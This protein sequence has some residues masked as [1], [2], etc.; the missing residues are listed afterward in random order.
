MN[1]DFVQACR[2]LI[3]FDTSPLQ[4]TVEMVNYLA[5]LA[6]EFG[7]DVQIQHEIQNG[8][9]Q[10]NI[11]I[12][13]QPFRPGDQEFLLQTHLDTVDPGSFSLWKKNSFNPFDAVIEDGKIFGLGA[14]EVKLD[15]LCKL[16][17]LIDLKDCHFKN[18]KPVLVGTFGEESGMQ[19][20]LKL[21][22]KNKINAKYALIGE[23]TNLNIVNS[24][25]G[26]ATVEIKIPISIE[27]QKHKSEKLISES[28]STQTK[29]F[30]GR[31]AHSSTPH[32]GESAAVKMF[33][34]LNQMPDQIVIVD[35]DSGTRVNTIPNQAMV[36]LDASAQI[37]QT[38]IR[39]IN[40]LFR[41]MSVVQEKM[42]IVTDADFEPMHSTLSVG[43]IRSHAEHI[44][45]GGSCRIL[46]S[47]SQDIYESWMNL[48]H[49]ACVEVGAEF[50]LLDYKR[51]FRTGENS[52][53]IK[54]AQ[55]ELQKLGIDSGCRSLASTN[56]ASLFSRLGIECLCLGAGLREGNVHTPSEYVSILDLEKA[57]IFYTKMIERFCL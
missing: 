3:G 17:A 4:S 38:S 54:A 36:E 33:E 47:V 41:A 27:E 24:A 30:S 39:K 1:F 49:N 29:L 55:A 14:A 57:I 51:P 12:R 28:T 45:I 18:L 35:I 52:V 44:F 34:F 5:H 6:G 11:L 8:I 48:I 10:A 23:P 46:P 37:Q 56:E 40:F 20:A 21:I 2:K 9:A 43:I 50:S 15:F 32:L 53:F 26:F 13:C 22:R 42:K 16:K 31:S 19:G 7:L 25:K